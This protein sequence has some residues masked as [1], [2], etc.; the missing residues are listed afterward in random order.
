MLALLFQIAHVLDGAHGLAGLQ[1]N[2]V[3]DVLAFSGGPNVGNLVNLEPVN[4]AGVGEDQKIGVRGC[5][6]HLLDKILFLGPHAHAAR[7][8]A[9]LLAIGG[10]RRALQIPG[11][12]NGDRDLLIND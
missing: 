12:G 2:Q 7:A 11:V 6:E 10:D 8:A 5:D 1:C 9:A 3:R 4:A